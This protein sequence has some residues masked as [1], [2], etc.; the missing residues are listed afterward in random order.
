MI[1]VVSCHHFPDD[2]RIYH[3]E[4]K[5]LLGKNI[6]IRY[7]TRSESD[8]DLSKPGLKH[9]NLSVNLS[10]K[11]YSKQILHQLQASEAP[12]FFH[13]HE[14]ELLPLAKSVKQRFRATIIYDVHEN[15]DAMYR[16]FSQRSKPVK[17]TAIFLKNTNEKRHLK[18]IDRVVLANQPMENTVYDSQGFQPVVLEN[19]PEIK[20]VTNVANNGNRGSSII[21]HGHLAPERGIGD[22]MAALPTVIS[23][24][25][26]VYLTLLG[27][28]RT[29][30]Y[31]RQI[32]RYILKNNL[33]DHVHVKDQIP[34]GDIW[35]ILNK[36]TVGVIPFRENPLTRNNTPTKL[37]EMMASGC[38][39]AASNLPPIRNFISDTVH[40]TTPG[41]IPSLA[42]GIIEAFRSLNQPA[43]IKENRNLIRKK[44]NWESKI[45]E[46]LK[47][48]H[49][50]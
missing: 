8:L 32:K 6:F 23:E 2:E 20:Y 10:V 9:I 25:P 12:L 38:R 42:V 14:P 39:I 17:E 34:Y 36:H 24:I 29:T 5:T 30:E 40:W 18:F 31:E 15:L 19:F 22:L 44:Y 48:Y 26:D 41:D 3:R 11:S 37:F 1:A 4:I 45:N 35:A 43:W 50:Q 21:Y 46:F 27:S 28:F 16:T 7:F 47:L 49:P 13:I 33:R